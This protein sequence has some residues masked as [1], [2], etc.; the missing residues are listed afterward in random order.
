MFDSAA[1]EGDL[2]GEIVTVVTPEELE[3]MRK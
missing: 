3:P 1:F 2:S